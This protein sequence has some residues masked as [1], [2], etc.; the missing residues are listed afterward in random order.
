MLVF[1]VKQ[2]LDRSMRIVSPKTKIFPVLELASI[3][4]ELVNQCAIGYDDMA[5]GKY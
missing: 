5:A 1:H 2:L 3:Q 4:N